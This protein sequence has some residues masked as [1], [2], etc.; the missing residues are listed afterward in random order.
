MRVSRFSVRP[1]GAGFSVSGFRIRPV[2]SIKGTGS[3]SG[4]VLSGSGMQERAVS[5]LRHQAVDP[6]HPP[7]EV[8][9]IA[10]PPLRGGSQTPVT[11]SPSDSPFPPQVRIV[12]LTPRS[13]EVARLMVRGFKP[14]QISRSLH[15]SLQSV[16][17]RTHA[18]YLVLNLAGLPQDV[19]LRAIRAALAVTRTPESAGWAKDFCYRCTC[20]RCRNCIE[21]AKWETRFSHL[22]DPDYYSRPPVPAFRSPIC[23]L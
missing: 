8:D 7:A 10:G 9:P 6:G 14:S 1:G 3:L 20:G 21:N 22:V 23:D 5:T 13:A 12:G 17:S 15:R 18:I 4:P 16:C 2:E 19:R 11:P